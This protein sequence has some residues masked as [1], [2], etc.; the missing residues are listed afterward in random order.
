M[1]KRI[2]LI[3]RIKSFLLY[4]NHFFK[5]ALFLQTG[6]T[7]NYFSTYYMNGYDPL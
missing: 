7:F 4:S 5:K 3:L 6:I 1:N 2:K